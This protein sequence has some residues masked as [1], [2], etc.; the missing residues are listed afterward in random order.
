MSR[1]NQAPMARVS[2]S[3]VS[4]LPPAIQKA[5]GYAEVHAPEQ[6]HRVG[7]MEMF[8]AMSQI[9]TQLAVCEDVQQVLDVVV[10]L[11]SEVSGFHRV[12]VASRV[13]VKAHALHRSWFND[14]MMHTTAV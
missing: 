12:C 4:R 14:S 6:E 2:T 8:S 13:D 3:S 5:M 7:F 10:G 1:S 9:Q 11:V